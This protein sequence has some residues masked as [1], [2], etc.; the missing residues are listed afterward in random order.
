MSVKHRHVCSPLILFLSFSFFLKKET[1]RGESVHVWDVTLAVG[2]TQQPV[3]RPVCIITA[4]PA[5]RDR[6][7][8]LRALSCKTQ[9]SHPNAGRPRPSPAQRCDSQT[10]KQTPANTQKSGKR[11]GKI[12]SLKAQ[13]VHAKSRQHFDGVFYADGAKNR[14]LSFFFIPLFHCDS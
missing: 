13:G 5:A 1:L 6:Q 7:T 10:A 9:T 8:R 11:K 14:L 12:L 4:C 2:T 3:Q